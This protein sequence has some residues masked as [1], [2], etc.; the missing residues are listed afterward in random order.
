MKMRLEKLLSSQG[1]GSR[2]IVKQYIKYQNV[3]VNNKIIIDPGYKVDTLLDDIIF[4]GEKIIYKE[5][6]YIALN[7]PKGYVCATKDNLNPPVLELID[8]NLRKNLH[9]VGRLDKDTTGLVLLTN[10]GKWS[11]DLKAPKK[12]IEKEYHV[13]LK[14]TL[15]DAMIISLL[16]PMKLDDKLLKPVKIKKI[17]SNEASIILI[18]GKH[19]QIKRM[20]N[21]VGNEVIELNRIRIG[22]LKLSDLNLREGNFK[23]IDNKEI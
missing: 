11:H 1:I 20:F 14:E 6:L 13:T 16:S 19:H 10:D 18:E 22:K 8:E 4:N 9:I 7:K 17:S 12:C 2:N 23:E 5:F 3:L 15:T 21:I